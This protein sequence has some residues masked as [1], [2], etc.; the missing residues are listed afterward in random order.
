MTTTYRPLLDILTEGR[1]LPDGCDFWGMRSVRPDFTSSRGFRWPFPGG[2]AEA[3]GPVIH[4]NRDAC[5]QSE[6]DGICTAI[7]AYGMASGG[8]PA[9]TVLITAHAAADVLGADE[10]KVRVRRATVVEVVDLPGMARAGKLSGADLS[11][12]NLGGAYLR[13]AYLGEAYLDGAD[14][15]GAY[16]DG[17]YLYGAYLGRANLG[18][19]NLGRAYL[20]GAYLGGAYLYGADLSG[21]NLVGADL[22]EANLRGAD[23]RGADLGEANLR[24]AD[25]SGANLV[26]ADLG[27][28]NADQYTRWPEGFN[29]ATTGVS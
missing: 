26:G 3:P 24:E 23:L 2:V 22:G 15:S 25:L 17:A 13:G 18:R 19:A 16:L 28:A 20:G 10:V 11:G 5:P 27:E 21:A 12:A 29:P 1:T 14:L 6:G 7:T 9:I 4:T 8:I